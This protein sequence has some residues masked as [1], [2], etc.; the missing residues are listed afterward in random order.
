VTIQAQ[1]LDLLQRLQ[2]ERKMAMQFITHDLGVISELA[3]R[4]IVMYAG[5]VV[6]EAPAAELF[7]HPRHPYTVGL[8]DSIPRTNQTQERLATIPGV[9]PSLLDLPQGCRF[10]NRCPHATETCRRSEPPLAASG[11]GLKVACYNPY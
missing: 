10:Q 9:V 2:D 5:K 8:L 3:D 1:I 6:E 11:P 4:V 7:A